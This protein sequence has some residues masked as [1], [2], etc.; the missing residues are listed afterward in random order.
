MKKI[1]FSLAASAL[2]LASCDPLID[3]KDFDPIYVSADELGGLITFAQ[4]SK[5]DSVTP[6]DNGNWITYKTNP[7]TVVSIYNLNAKGE[8]N[9]LAYGGTDGAFLLSPKRKSSTQQ[10]VYISVANSDGTTTVAEKTFNVYVPEKL[11]PEMELLVSDDGV[12]CWKWDS[13]NVLYEGQNIA[14][15]NC[16]YGCTPS[17]WDKGVGGLWWGTTPEGLTDQLKHSDTGK[18]TTEESITAFMVFDEDGNIS[19]YGK[20]GK[21]IRKGNFSV[22]GYNNGERDSKTGVIATLTTKA[23]SILF[24]FKI[25]GNG[26]KPTDF[27]IMFLDENHMRLRYAPEG[28]ASDGEATWWAF[29]RYD[30]QKFIAGEGTKT[31]TWD[32]EVVANGGSWGNIG[33]AAASGGSWQD[34]IQGMWW[35]CPP[36]E[37]TG[38]LNHSDTGVATGEEDPDA[39]MIFDSTA[40]KVTSYKADG[41]QIRQGKY[42]ITNWNG[43]AHYNASIDGS[44]TCWSQGTL[45]TDAGSILWPF[46][47]NAASHDGVV[48]PTNFEITYL[49]DSALRIV[50]VSAGTD[51]WAEATFWAFKARKE[52]GDETGGSETGGSETGGSETGG[53][54]SGSSET[55]GSE[56]GS[57]EAGGSESGSTE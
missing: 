35:A 46:Q 25:N 20:D 8:Q 51:S 19:T 49:D 44:Q 17:D 4:Y 36:A 43:G 1:I 54:E 56:P 39:Y 40:G 47:I 9:L 38:Q 57:S 10:K 37:L 45:T 28:T 50:C 7:A 29:E 27:D 31:W 34:G 30:A 11:T 42:S 18:K 41:T 55:G 13:N 2:V 53:S 14:W 5:A 12:K 48:K 3:E 26:A 21:C 6:A 33:Y 32:T 24:P 16:S 22:K 15:G 52:G 23:G